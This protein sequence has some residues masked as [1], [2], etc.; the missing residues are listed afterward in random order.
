MFVCSVHPESSPQKVGGVVEMMAYPWK[1]SDLE[2][3][4]VGFL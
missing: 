1:V 2:I 3:D 4:D